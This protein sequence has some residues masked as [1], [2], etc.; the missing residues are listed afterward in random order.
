MLYL[1]NYMY[2]YLFHQTDDSFNWKSSF[3]KPDG[4]KNVNS[5]SMLLNK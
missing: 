4:Y 5:S 2:E 1:F 3:C